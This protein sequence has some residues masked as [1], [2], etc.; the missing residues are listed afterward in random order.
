MMRIIPE[1]YFLAGEQLLLFGGA[2]LL[3]IPAGLCVDLFRILRTIFPHHSLA[4]ALEDI[5]CCLLCSLFLMCYTYA[6]ARGEFRMYYAAG[7]LIGFLL[8]ECTVGL[9]LVQFL[10]RMLRPWKNRKRIAPICRKM[11]KRF[12][13]SAEK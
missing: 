5:L 12:G 11:G 9:I 8:Y 13:K 3:G 10:R 2:C 1:T 6:F 7:M 4:V